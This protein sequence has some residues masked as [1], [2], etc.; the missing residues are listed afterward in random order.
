MDDPAS[1][2]TARLDELEA[3]ARAATCG[4]HG[5][6]WTTGAGGWVQVAEHESGF[7]AEIDDPDLSVTVSEL[8]H[9]GEDMAEHIALHDPAAV[10]ADVDSKRRILAEHR[11]GPG[12]CITC[13]DRDYPED[14]PCATAK[15]LVL[16]FASHP[17]YREGWAV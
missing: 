14:Y 2:L 3:A 7:Q 11:A 5:P 12:G 1:F 13:T 9:L 16:P 10:L 6:M 8:E 4:S 17:D 15:L